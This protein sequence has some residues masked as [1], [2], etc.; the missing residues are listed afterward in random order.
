MGIKTTYIIKNEIQTQDVNSMNLSSTTITMVGDDGSPLLAKAL[1]IRTSSLLGDQEVQYGLRPSW[2]R[3]ETAVVG[4]GGAELGSISKLLDL[5]KEVGK[6]RSRWDG[7]F[8]ITNVFPYSAV[9]LRDEANNKI[10]KV[11][12]HQIKPYYKG[13]SSI[14]CEVESISLTEP[15]IPEDTL[16]KSPNPLMCICIEDNASFKGGIIVGNSNPTPDSR[17][18]LFCRVHAN[19]GSMLGLAHYKPNNRKTMTH[20][21]LGGQRSFGIVLGVGS[22]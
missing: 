13:P 17:R 6:L 9:E 16:K 19:S 21:N 18:V 20:L 15:A 12:G 11:N 7:P 1:R 14:V 4:T 8:V 2:P 3:K 10:F 5:Q 22:T